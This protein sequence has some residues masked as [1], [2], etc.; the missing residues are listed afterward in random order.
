M[1]TN[2][3]AL[4][5]GIQGFTGSYMQAELTAAGYRVV[6]LGSHAGP[7]QDDYRQVNLVD[8]AAVKQTIQDIQ[9]SVIVHLAAVAFVG[10]GNANAF[11]EVNLIGTRNLL[12]GIAAMDSIPDC[13]LLAS[14]ANVYGNAQEGILSEDT[15][16]APANH[17]AVSKLAMEHMATL[18]SAIFPIVI[19]R[20]F[21]Y[22]GL[23]QSDKFLIPKI[24]S[25]FRSKAP[26]IELGNLDV[27][28]DFSDVR[29]I[30]QA[31]RRLLEVPSAAG[32]TVNV[33]SGET[34]SLRE[35][36]DICSTITGHSLNVHVNPAFV[37]SN[38]IKSLCGD[39]SRLRGLI[40]VWKSVPLA[41]TLQWMLAVN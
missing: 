18:Y 27:W 33:C 20:P 6:G 3:T 9:P 13:V 31:Y 40:G 24:V 25:H 37:R 28:R 1:P 34:Y 38:E 12:E 30:A 19:A 17:Y 2:K 35:I 5:T 26:I 36:I 41:K 23:G 32:Q 22:T 4:I 11:Y 16:P 7:D 39:G 21:N 15:V 14:S 8:G 29:S 10:H